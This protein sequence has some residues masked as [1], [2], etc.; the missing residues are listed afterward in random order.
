MSIVYSNT[1]TK[2]GI[3]QQLE[4][5]IGAP[6]AYISGDSTRLKQFTA[7]INLALD[8]FTAI[9]IQ[10]S[11]TW[12][13]DDTNHTDFPEGTTALVDGQRDYA[14]TADENGNLLLDIHRVFIKPSATATEYVE[15]YPRDKQ[16]ELGVTGFNDGLATEGQ[17]SYYDKTGNII[18]LDPIPSYSV[19][20]GL[21]VLFNREASYFTTSDTTKKPGVPTLFH[22]Y[23]VLRP[24]E[25]YARRNNLA[26]Y[27]LIRAERL[28]MEQSIKEYFGL[29]EKD[30]RKRITTRGIN[31]H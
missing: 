13:F 8:D 2:A 1:T 18:S 17:P 23:F 30:V 22:R 21:K 11:G 9:A 3:L 27:P 4:R 15:V 24:A 20:A 26:N 31:F 7:D 14:L 12:Q 6:D 16:S 28:Q 25:D 10:S 5:E 29:R 19:S